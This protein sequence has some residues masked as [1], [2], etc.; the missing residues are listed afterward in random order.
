ML[1]H[2]MAGAHIHMG[3]MAG[4]LKGVMPAQTPSG[5]RIEY[6]STPVEACSEKW[7]RSRVGMPQACSTTS[8]PRVTSPI[9]SESTLPC[10]SVRI[11]AMSSRRSCTSSRTANMSSARFARESARQAGN[12]SRA[13]ATARS[14]SSAVARSTAPLCSPVAGL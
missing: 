6:T 8:S 10:S 14:T 3:T 1:P 2:A 12:A 5:W 9:A 11:R 4:K 13:A 7:P